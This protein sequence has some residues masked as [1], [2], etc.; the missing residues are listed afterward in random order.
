MKKEKKITEKTFGYKDFVSLT[1]EIRECRKNLPD[2]PRKEAIPVL[3]RMYRCLGE[4]KRSLD[5][6]ENNFVNWMNGKVCSFVHPYTKNKIDVQIGDDYEAIYHFLLYCRDIN[7]GR[8]IDE[9]SAE[10]LAYL[11][12]RSVYETEGC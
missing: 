6:Q 8:K 2:T 9:N 4:I 3:K 5:D 7:A 1:N 10:Y 12:S 11:I